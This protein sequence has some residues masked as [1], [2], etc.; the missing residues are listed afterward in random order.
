M[1]AGAVTVKASNAAA[2]VIWPVPPWVR[3]IVAPP[4]SELIDV[5]S[6]ARAASTWVAVI[7]LAASWIPIRAAPAPAACDAK[8]EL[9]A[10]VVIVKLRPKTE[11]PTSPRAP[12]TSV[13]VYQS[14]ASASEVAAAVEAPPPP[15]PPPPPTGAP[16]M[17]KPGW[18][19][20]ASRGDAI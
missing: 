18:R 4:P 1:S 9:S 2:A 15:P 6:S 20:P 5:A 7:R 16:A 12:S 17:C 10:L 19:M 11:F 13:D 8:V 14:P 3:G